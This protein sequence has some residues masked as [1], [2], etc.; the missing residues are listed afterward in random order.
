[1]IFGQRTQQIG[2]EVNEKVVDEMEY[3]RCSNLSRESVK[4]SSPPKA[5]FGHRKMAL[6]IIV[7]VE[8]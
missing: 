4:D 2:L 3:S 7:V 1:M 6:H 5:H 8:L